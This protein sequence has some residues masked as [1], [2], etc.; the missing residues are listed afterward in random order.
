ML[1]QST[2]RNGPEQDGQELEDVKGTSLGMLL[3]KYLLTILGSR[4]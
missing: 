3:F 2:E 1:L 4:I